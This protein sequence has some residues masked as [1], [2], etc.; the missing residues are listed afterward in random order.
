MTGNR[1]FALGVGFMVLSIGTLFLTY[2]YE[3]TWRL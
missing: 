3:N 1:L 2:G